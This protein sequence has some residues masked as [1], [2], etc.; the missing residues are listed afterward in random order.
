MRMARID[1]MMHPSYRI[2]EKK[3]NEMKIF[4]NHCCFD[5]ELKR[6]CFIAFVGYQDVSI[7]EE[8][9]NLARETVKKEWQIYFASVNGHR[10]AEGKKNQ[11]NWDLINRETLGNMEHQFKLIEKTGGWIKG[12][13]GLYRWFN[14]GLI[15]QDKLDDNGND[16]ASDVGAPF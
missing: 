15:L 1:Y 12:K 11:G 3:R 6:C 16:G 5:A 7:G 9:I 4:P 2:T 13:H 8:V 10:N 14:T